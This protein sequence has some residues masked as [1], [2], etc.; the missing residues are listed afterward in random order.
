[1]KLRCAAVF[2]WLC[3]LICTAALSAQTRRALLIGINTCEPAGTSATHPPGCT[4]GRCELGYFENLDGPP[5][6]SSTLLRQ[7]GAGCT[8]ST[9]TAS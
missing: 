3:C 5:I 1:M 9:S 4:Y 6:A 8:F 7:N 2:A